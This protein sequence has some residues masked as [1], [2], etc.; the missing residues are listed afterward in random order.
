MCLMDVSHKRD[1]RGKPDTTKLK[2][3][4]P[5]ICQDLQ[6]NTLGQSH[7]Q[8]ASCNEEQEVEDMGEKLLALSPLLF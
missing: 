5:V 4:W 8:E 6:I 2:L 1:Q 3:N 7:R